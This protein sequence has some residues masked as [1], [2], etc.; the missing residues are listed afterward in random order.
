M[1]PD[2]EQ[3]W[4]AGYGSLMIR[5]HLSPMPK[6]DFFIVFFYPVPSYSNRVVVQ[7]SEPKYT[8][9]EVRFRT[10][11]EHILPNNPGTSVS[12]CFWRDRFPKYVR[13]YASELLPKRI[14]LNNF[15]TLF[16][17]GAE[18]YSDTEDAFNICTSK[19]QMDARL[20]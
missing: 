15:E 12:E 4:N 20:L 1:Y 13:T 2:D 9:G 17:N 19:I 3:S 8:Q 16:P 7:H 10:V 18:T 11:S 6:I 5:E 14:L